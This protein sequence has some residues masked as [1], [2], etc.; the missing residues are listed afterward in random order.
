[1]LFVFSSSSSRC[2]VTQNLQ[3]PEDVVARFRVCAGR[4]RGQQPPLLRARAAAGSS[5]RTQPASPEP[6]VPAVLPLVGLLRGFHRGPRAQESVQRTAP[7]GGFNTRSAASCA[8]WRK[9]R[10]GG[11]KGVIR[12]AGDSLFRVR[13]SLGFIHLLRVNFSRLRVLVVRSLGHT[14]GKGERSGPI[15]RLS[16]LNPRRHGTLP[17]HTLIVKA[18]HSYLAA[19]PE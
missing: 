18:S 12:Q 15:S 4:T 3:C 6:P 9:A 2:F 11:Q 14:R 1:M 16:Q 10:A 19:P 7:R 8:R 5:G 17:Y 13:P